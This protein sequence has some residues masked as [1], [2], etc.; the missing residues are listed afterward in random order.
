MLSVLLQRTDSRHQAVELTRFPSGEFACILVEND[1]RKLVRLAAPPVPP[2]SVISVLKLVCNELSAVVVLAAVDVP[3]VVLAV[4]EPLDVPERDWSKLLTSAANL[5]GPPLAEAAPVLGVAPLAVVPASCDLRAVMRLCMKLCKAW[6]RSLADVVPLDDADAAVLA[7][8]LVLEVA[9]VLAT[10]PVLVAALVLDAELVAPADDKAAIRAAI[11]PPWGVV[12]E[13]PVVDEDPPAPPDRLACI[14][15]ACGL[16]ENVAAVPDTEVTLITLLLV[17]KGFTV[18]GE[19]W[20]LA[21]KISA[22]N[23]NRTGLFR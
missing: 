8:P 22:V 11:M 16:G 2:K 13:D 12:P 3:L 21:S 15:I 18:R 4:V 23:A 6:A 17:L 14:A 7:V 19:P 5:P 1:C 20:F 10:A 9:P